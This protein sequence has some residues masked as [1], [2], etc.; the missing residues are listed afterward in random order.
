MCQAVVRR[1]YNSLKVAMCEKL[2][3]YWRKL[4]AGSLKYLLPGEASTKLTVEEA[5]QLMIEAQY[6]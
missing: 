4:L 1:V 3:T 5:V 6:C 2:P